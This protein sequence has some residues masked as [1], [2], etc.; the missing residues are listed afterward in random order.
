MESFLEQESAEGSDN[1]EMEANGMKRKAAET[2]EGAK[3]SGEGDSAP[4]A[5]RK[6]TDSSG[7]VREWNSFVILHACIDRL[8]R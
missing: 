7:Q 2:E 3:A 6:K 1:L 4:A 5:K 8:R